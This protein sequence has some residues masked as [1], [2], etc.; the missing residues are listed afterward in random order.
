M[1]KEVKQIADMQSK[2]QDQ[3]PQ[4]VQAAQV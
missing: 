2:W 4:V 1:L 3:T